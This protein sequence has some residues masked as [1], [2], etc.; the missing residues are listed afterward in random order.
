[1]TRSISRPF[2]SFSVS[3]SFNETTS[4]TIGYRE[5]IDRPGFQSLA[6][7]FFFLNPFTV[8]T[9]NIQA[10]PNIS[11]TIETTLNYQAL[12]I[13][14]SY[15]QEDNPIIPFA[16]P[17]I[18]QER[19]L[20]LLISDNIENREQW[21]LNLNFPLDFSSFWTSTYSFGAYH[22]SDDINLRELQITESNFYHTLNTSQ[23]FQWG[24]EWGAELNAFWDSDFFR[25][26][27]RQPARASVSVG[28]SKTFESGGKLSASWTDIFDTGTFL[29]MENDLRDQGIFYDWN[30]E[31]EGSIFRLAYSLPL[32][33]KQSKSSRESNA[34]DVLKRTGG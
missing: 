19:N 30:Y 1:V 10:R 4:L 2:P 17:I 14:L 20:L 6:P 33:G 18:D 29:G 16:Q 28:L 15:S 11:K 22:R 3:K 12:S 13:S 24:K 8:L 5:R 7:A 23:R 9:G 32:G 21:G 27:I 25:G 34:T 31:F 26:T